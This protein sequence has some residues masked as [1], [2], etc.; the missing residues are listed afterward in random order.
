MIIRLIIYLFKFIRFHKLLNEAYE[1]DNIP[2]SVSRLLGVP[3]HIDFFNRIY[4][5][6]HPLTQQINNG[7]SAIFAINPDGTYNAEPSIKMWLYD[8]LE[9]MSKFIAAQNLLDCLT[10]DLKKIDDDNWLLVM[11]PVTFPEFKKRLTAAI[12]EIFIIIA[13]LGFYIFFA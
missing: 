12:I 3:M 10:L 7:A 1:V 11:S 2:I 6:L 5:V 13:L 4:G 9:A 8:R